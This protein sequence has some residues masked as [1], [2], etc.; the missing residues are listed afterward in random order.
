MEFFI[1]GCQRSGTTLLRLIM[2]SHPDIRCFG[3]TRAYN[4]LSDGFRVV[5][6]KKIDP[7]YNSE[8]TTPHIGYQVPGWSELFTEYDSVRKQWGSLPIVYMLRDPR[9]V[10]SSMKRIPRYLNEE[11]RG[12][13]NVWMNDENRSFEENFGNEVRNSIGKRHEG[14]IL[15]S[16]FWKY[17]T[18]PYLQMVAENYNVLGVFYDDL[19][20][21][22]EQEVRRISEFLEI[23]FSLKTL[24]HHEMPHGETDQKTKITMGNTRTDRQIDANSLDLWKGMDPEEAKV[25]NRHTAK[26]VRQIGM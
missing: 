18:K 21:K 8:I 6:N 15:G 3:E 2:D 19:C 25:I 9:A 22:P 14:I 16:I 4:I 12:S 10:V 20:Q 26:L 13:I 7:W 23:P 5:E 17:R 11:V 1:T 24:Q